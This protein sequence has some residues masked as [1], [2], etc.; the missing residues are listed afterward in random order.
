MTSTDMRNLVCGATAGAVSRTAVSPLERLKILYQT[1]HVTG[2]K[3]SNA[4]YGSMSSSLRTIY[5][6]EGFKGFY[7]GNGVNVMRVLPYTGTQF[8]CFDKYKKLLKGGD[9][10][11]PL[12]SYEKLLVGASAGTTSVL[13]TYPLDL[14]RGRITVQGGGSAVKYTGMLDCLRKSVAEEGFFGLYRG[15][16]ANV[17][18]II[19]Y[20]GVNYLVY[21]TC[22]E[23][24]PIPE[25]RTT[26]APH[27]LALC[28]GIA[29]TTGQTVAYPMDLLR[30]R[31]QVANEYRNV[32]H[33][34][35][36]ICKEEGVGGLYKGYGPNFIKTW[37]TIAIM[38]FVND[39]MKQ[40]DLVNG[41]FGTA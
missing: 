29:G 19:P 2:H 8:M 16:T 26:P 4:K 7:R 14:I 41:V 38:F 9:G 12:A 24:A 3:G 6:Q 5:R 21:E 10:T 17:I 25:G 27:Y 23:N 20:V 33:A 37:P 15:M 39:M 1:Q 32:V 36:T 40:S 11:A 31:F 30:R 13:V 34:V 22:K 35:Q 28:G 18:G